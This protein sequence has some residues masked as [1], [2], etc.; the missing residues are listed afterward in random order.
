[1]PD[2]FRAVTLSASF[3]LSS[4]LGKLCYHDDPDIAVP[5]ILS[6]HSAHIQPLMV[7]LQGLVGSDKGRGFEV[8]RRM[9]D[10]AAAGKRKSA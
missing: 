1:M 9:S 2:G 7:S 6:H 8:L 5:R 10:L 4:A 3:G